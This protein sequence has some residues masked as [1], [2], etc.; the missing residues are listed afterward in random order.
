[1]PE[2]QRERLAV[3]LSKLN[4]KVCILQTVNGNVDG[5]LEE[6]ASVGN[7]QTLGGQHDPS[8]ILRSRLLRRQLRIGIRTGFLGEKRETAL[9]PQGTYKF[10]GGGTGTGDWTGGRAP[11][12]RCDEGRGSFLLDLP[13]VYH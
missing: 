1:M 4:G 5:K 3:A 9:R 6:L 12:A 11:W 13:P 2:S 8:P 10:T 7:G